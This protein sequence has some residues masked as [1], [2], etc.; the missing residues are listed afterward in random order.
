[1]SEVL[2]QET[3]IKQMGVLSGPNIAPEIAAGKPAGTVVASRFPRVIAEALNLLV[4][5]RFRVYSGQDVT[6][7]ELAGAL[8]NVVAIAG[9][10]ATQLQ[11][12]D[13]AKALLVTRGLTEMTRLGVALGARSGTF[14]GVAG[15][16]DL[17]VTCASPMSRN[18]RV[19]AGL[20]RGTKL[21]QVVRE[22]GMVAEGVNTSQ[23]AYEMIRERRL[24]APV[25]E[26]VYKMVHQGLSPKKALDELMR[27]ES[28]PDVDLTPA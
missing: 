6:G 1:M 13:N 20:A 9:G 25:F 4:S 14:C 2:F 5:P 27:L 18:H 23:V 22:L 26:G 17:I 7:V 15:L 12:G 19:G 16:G 3:C 24:Y 11:L 21:T 28:R 10:I 8:K